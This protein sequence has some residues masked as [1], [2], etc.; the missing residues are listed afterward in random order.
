MIHKENEGVAIARKIGIENATGEYSIHFDSD[1]WAEP[2]MLEELYNKAKI[3]KFRYGN[4]RLFYQ[5]RL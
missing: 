3:E 1:D 4:C 2:T 5:Y